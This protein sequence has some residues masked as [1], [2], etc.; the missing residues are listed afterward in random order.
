MGGLA[1]AVDYTQMATQRQET[2]NALDAAGI[3][4]ARRIVEGADGTQATAYAKEFFEANLGSVE[5]A[6]T[7][8]SVVLPQNN[9]GGGTLKLCAALTYKP[10]LFPAF[11]KMI[12]KTGT[13]DFG[14]S[15]CSEV[16]LKN[17]LEV[18]LVLD[19]SGSMGETGRGSGKKRID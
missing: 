3:A 7:A 12:Q 6:N 18:A 17:T 13:T 8:L 14:F 5:P 2:L 9:T 4:T 11:A 15:T 1:L 19:N 10:F 16:R